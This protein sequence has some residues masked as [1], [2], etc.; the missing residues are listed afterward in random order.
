MEQ[1]REL[2][3][4]TAVTEY[5][6]GQINRFVSQST[7]L[8]PSGSKKQTMEVMRRSVLGSSLAPWCFR[9]C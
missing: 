9:L 3:C 5:V 2:V 7:F 8:S 6:L 4:A 1:I